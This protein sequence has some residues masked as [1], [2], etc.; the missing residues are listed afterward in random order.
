MPGA[1]PPAFVFDGDA[2]VENVEVTGMVGEGQVP[3]TGQV[4]DPEVHAVAHAAQETLP[5]WEAKEPAA[6]G[7]QVA[8]PAAAA[9]V[10]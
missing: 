2:P 7:V 6:H 10:P 4:E 8:L 1:Q 5:G 3:E 9:K